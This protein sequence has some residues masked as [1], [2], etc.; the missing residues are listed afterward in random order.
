MTG[1]V[2]SLVV[3]RG[4]GFLYAEGGGEL[5]FHHSECDGDFKRLEGHTV[6]YDVAIRNGR[7]QAVN[8]RLAS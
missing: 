4:F 7:D 6:T 8:V 5:F 1:V 2:K 3:E